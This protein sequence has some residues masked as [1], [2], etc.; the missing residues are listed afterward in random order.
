MN[1][2]T[3]VSLIIFLG[4][5]GTAL[6]LA[7]RSDK[8][9]SE[10]GYQNP[11]DLRCIT[12]AGIGKEDVLNCKRDPE[13]FLT[14]LYNT[15][16]SSK[17]VFDKG[18]FG[19]ALREKLPLIIGSDLYSKSTI[20]YFDDKLLFDSGSDDSFIYSETPISP[21]QSTEYFS[22][23]G[24]SKVHSIEEKQF[25]GLG[26]SVSNINHI[27]IS[28]V[29]FYN[30]ISQYRGVIGLDFLI[31]AKS[32]CLDMENGILTPICPQPADAIGRIVVPNNDLLF[33]PITYENKHLFALVDTGASRTKYLSKSC[34]K[35][36][37]TTGVDAHGNY[38]TEEGER[39]YADITIG[40]ATI[41]NVLVDCT[42]NDS[43]NPYFILGATF[44]KMNI[45]SIGFDFETNSYSLSVR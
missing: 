24:Q 4:V 14:K 18:P 34:K 45:K 1:F 40:S 8:S 12:I 17:L 36:T 10:N 28:E 19:I 16:P 29:S 7:I 37:K 35:T 13:A 3:I 2:K 27:D 6:A 30:I 39:T 22:Y 20:L 25:T 9:L 11:V 38:F 41:R 26:F 44:F 42:Y 33:M 21:T 32:V 23:T 15:P 31:A 5:I 43:D